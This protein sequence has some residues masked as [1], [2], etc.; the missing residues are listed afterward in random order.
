[1]WIMKMH[2]ENELITDLFMEEKKNKYLNIRLC[3]ADPASIF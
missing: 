1:M 3:P 2:V